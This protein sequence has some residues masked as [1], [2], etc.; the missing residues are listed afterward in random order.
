[1]IQKV[2]WLK[3][4][5]FTFT[6]PSGQLTAS[7]SGSSF[8]VMLTSQLSGS[9]TYGFTASIEDEHHFSTNTESMITITQSDTGTLG[10][11]TTSYIIESELVESSK[12]CNGFGGGNAFSVNC[13]LFTITWFTISTIIYFI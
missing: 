9:T 12:R 8:K 7:L 1:M 10:G 6:E 4:S 5:H 13:K 3:H 2:M 11:D